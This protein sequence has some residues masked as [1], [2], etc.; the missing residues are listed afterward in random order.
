MV[1]ACAGVA[2]R[3]GSG[4]Q[5]R[6]HGFESRHSLRE[7]W[8]ANSRPGRRA[9]AAVQIENPR[10]HRVSHKFQRHPG[11]VEDFLYRIEQCA[12]TLAHIVE[13]VLR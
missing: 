6:I 13:V 8:A 4:L 1:V 3:L 9:Y 5:S 11:I 10:A 2:E 12:L 7:S